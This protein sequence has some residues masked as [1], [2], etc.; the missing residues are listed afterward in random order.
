MWTPDY[1]LIPAQD[2]T[3]Q[4]GAATTRRESGLGTKGVTNY[5]TGTRTSIHPDFNPQATQPTRRHTSCKPDGREHGHA[6]HPYTRRAQ[7]ASAIGPYNPCKTANAAAAIWPGGNARAKFRALTLA[8]TTPS[9]RGR[10]RASP[11]GPRTWAGDRARN[12]TPACNTGTAAKTSTKQAQRNAGQHSGYS[13][14]SLH[15]LHTAEI[16]QQANGCRKEEARASTL[17]MAWHAQQICGRGHSASTT[18]VAAGGVAMRV[19]YKQGQTAKER[20]G[21]P[22]HNSLLRSMAP[23]C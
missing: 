22:K 1:I 5:T 10:I 14:S 6:P 19:Q 16:L 3:Q 8:C 9:P 11:L 18:S 12:A 13:N 17:C 20:Q 7:P 23:I 2:A 4:R 21:L 15:T